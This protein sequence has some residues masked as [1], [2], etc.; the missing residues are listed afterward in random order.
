VTSLLWVLRR[1]L[2]AR[3]RNWAVLAGIVGLAGAVVLTAAAGARRTD[4]AYQ[5][6]L[7]T[8][9]AANVL[10][11]PNNTG[12]HPLLGQHEMPVAA[13]SP[14]TT[15]SIYSGVDHLGTVGKVGPR[16]RPGGSVLADGV[17]EPRG[18]GWTL[19]LE[20]KAREQVNRRARSGVDGLRGCLDRRGTQ[21]ERDCER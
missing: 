20:V 17:R 5:R 7:D 12:V 8:A 4:S 10:V 21:L 15:Y 11:S 14:M 13:P 19:G 9:H 2:R 3:W 16:A 18:P 6:F 1:Q